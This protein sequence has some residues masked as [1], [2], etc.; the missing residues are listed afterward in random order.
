MFE[1][2]IQWSLSHYADLP[3][4]KKRSLYGTL[5]SEIMLQQTTVGTVLNHYERFL[6]EFPDIKKLAQASENE[7]LIS[8]KGLGYYRRAKNLLSA[9]KIIDQKFNGKIP[10]DLE[11][12]LTIKGIGP[13][14]ANALI[15][16]GQDKKALALDA[17]LERVLARFYNISIEKGPKLHKKIYELFYDDKILQIKKEIS[18]RHL[19]EALMDLGRVFCQAK[20]AS[21]ELCSL[22]AQCQIFKSGANPL[23]IPFLKEK[24]T[25][26]FDLKLLRIVKKRGNK[27]LCYKKKSHEWLSGQNEL[28]TFIISSGD[29]KIKQYPFVDFEVDLNTLPS[30][31]TTI[32]KYKITN[33]VLEDGK[34]PNT[35][36]AFEDCTSK[37]INLSTASLKALKKIGHIY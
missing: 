6:H 10:T 2:L 27:V 4:R 18:Y 15:S 1:K 28:P 11:T 36:Y 30:Y 37:E 7:I 34:F 31:K 3:W 24:K 35:G 14:T 25:E 21:C 12:L 13:Y 17:N 19:N 32:T 33:Y 22:N 8:W 26:T 20:K 29:K 9:A 23:S 16:I 5:V